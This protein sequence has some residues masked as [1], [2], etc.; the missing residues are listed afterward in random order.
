MMK[1]PLGMS[2]EE[3]PPGVPEEE[4]PP[5]SPQ[6]RP[7]KPPPGAREEERCGGGWNFPPLAYVKEEE[8]CGSREKLPYWSRACLFVSSECLLTM[9]ALINV[10]KIATYLAILQ[11]KIVGM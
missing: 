1:P 10:D 6:S 5:T 8:R 9:P 3:E 7:M 4:P 2:E 11:N